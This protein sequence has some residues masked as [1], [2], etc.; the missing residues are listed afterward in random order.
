MFSETLV[1]L[2]LTRKHKSVIRTRD[3]Q[4]D[5]LEPTVKLGSETP[6]P[7]TGECRTTRAHAVQE[8]N[9]V[10]WEEGVSNL[11]SDTSSQTCLMARTHPAVSGSD[12]PAACWRPCLQLDAAFS[13]PR[14]IHHS[15]PCSPASRM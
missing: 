15:L 4:A 14:E 13:R 11:M 12:P 6:S 9:G 3:C 5:A 8:G 7:F 1:T 2:L 10:L